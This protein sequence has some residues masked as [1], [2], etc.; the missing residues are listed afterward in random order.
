MT[1]NF[2]QKSYEA[3]NLAIGR[4]SGEVAK[5]LGRS[6]NLVYRWQEPSGD[7]SDSGAWNPLDRLEAVIKT[8]IECGQGDDAFEPVRWLCE[9]FGFVAV[10][11][12][13]SGQA[14]LKI[15]RALLEEIRE[16]GELVAAVEESI[17]EGSDGGA[18]ITRRES[19]RILTEGRDL[20][21]QTSHLM[22]LV[23]LSGRRPA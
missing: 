23:K 17:G 14:D 15:L 5:A 2:N 12:P 4:H 8:A 16:F 21:R 9:R 1:A 19:R 6:R 11:L 3:L 13:A 18:V 7:W 10:K 22:E 20:I